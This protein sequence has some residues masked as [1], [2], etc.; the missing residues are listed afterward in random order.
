M[1]VSTATDAEPPITHPTTAARSVD[2]LPWERRARLVSLLTLGWNATEAV[3]AL[4]AA[5]LA[6]SPALLG[7]GLDSVVESLSSAVMIW[8]FQHLDQSQHREDRALKL[9]G[10]SLLLLAAFVAFDASSALWHREEPAASYVGIVL[11]IVSIALM[12]VLARWKRRIANEIDSGA[13]HADATQTDICWL[14]AMILLA[15]I[16]LNAV[17][18]WWWADPVAALAMVPLIAKEGYD[19]VRG[20]SCCGAG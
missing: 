10:A 15:G 11:A 4:T 3:V 8:R 5:L 18:G 14:L 9:V 19:A 7:F 20:K 12:P 17:F 13:L 6:N 16:C 2:R 1:D